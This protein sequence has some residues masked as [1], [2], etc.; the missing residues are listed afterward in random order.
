M[1][2]LKIKSLI[3]WK[4][5][6]FVILGIG[7]FIIHTCINLGWGDD[8]EMFY[9]ILQEGNS[10]MI[11]FL[12]DRYHSWS[13]RIFIEALLVI[14]VHLEPLWRILDTA[15]IILGAVSISKL[16]PSH[17]ERATNWIIIGLLFMYP[18]THMGSAGWMATTLNYL[19]PLS[20]GL[21]A[22][23]PIKKTLFNEK[24][25]WYE[26]LLYIPALIFSANQEQMS[27][28]LF[29]VYLMVSIYLFFNKKMNGFLFIQTIICLMSILFILTTPGNEIRKISEVGRWFPDY[30]NISF[31]RK[32]E[33]GFSSSWFE[34]VMKPNVIF[35]VFS[36][37]LMIGMMTTQKNKTYQW[38]AFVPITSS[39]IFGLL[40][41]V[42]GGLFPGFFEIKNSMTQYG[43]GVNFVSIISWIPDIILSLVFLS[44]LV[45]LF[46]VFSDK[47]YS[48]VTI[49][50][51]L[52]G[53]GSRLLMAFSP[54]I[55]AS[56]ERTFIFMYFAFLICS[57]FLYVEIVK[58]RLNKYGTIIKIILLILALLSFLNTLYTLE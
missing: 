7:M 31:I 43:T 25:F 41:P 12:N 26:Y 13:S 20:F 51:I 4:Y 57:V 19:W 37:L 9:P 53:F 11:S 6:P 49:F 21:I 48:I 28:I 35:I 27:A 32:I 42:L 16:V 30:N 17:H 33:M 52:L 46:L 58:V 10:N 5:F 54:T 23:I 1:E 55:W 50:I 40:S 39:L 34:F 29:A 38:I 22:M 47:K 45:S 24:I 36:L 15:I 56:V 18:F 8:K 2:F 3:K 44:I 14:L